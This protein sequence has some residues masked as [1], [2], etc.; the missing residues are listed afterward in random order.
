[1]PVLIGKYIIII[2]TYGRLNALFIGRARHTSIVFPANCIADTRRITSSGERQPLSRTF[3]ASRWSDVSEGNHCIEPHQD[4]NTACA[5]YHGR[6][7]C[8]CRTYD[9]RMPSLSAQRSSWR[10]AKNIVKTRSGRAKEIRNTMNRGR[11]LT[12]R[13]QSSAATFR[14]SAFTVIID[15]LVAALQKRSQAYEEISTRFG[16]L[17]NVRSITQCRRRDYLCRQQHWLNGFLMMAW[18]PACP[19]NLCNSRHCWTPTSDGKLRALPL[20]Q[21]LQ[22]TTSMWSPPERQWSCACTD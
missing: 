8:L 20:S 2:T 14:V 19:A 12:R 1:M 7:S 17:R 10:I 15:S 11:S 6:W 3:C 21:M 13:W 9:R 16:F 4:V 5:I 18:R 22:M